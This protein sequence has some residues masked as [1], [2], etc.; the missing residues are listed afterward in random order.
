MIIIYTLALFCIIYYIERKYFNFRIINNIKNFNIKSLI[1]YVFVSI[2]FIFLIRLILNEIGFLNIGNGNF[3]IGNILSILFSIFISPFVEEYIF[4][5]IPFNKSKSILT[6]IIVSLIFTFL[7]STGIF[8]SIFI[9]FLS[10]L[11]SY[12]YIKK[13]S[14]IY[15]YS[16]HSTYN[17]ISSI[18]YYT[19][20][21]YKILII[22]ASILSIIL[23]SVKNVRKKYK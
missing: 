10:I 21:S 14:I 3:N 20:K 17:L 11:F 15:T 23:V 13:K 16:I 5:Y 1:Y 4:R 22:I 12:I 9:F 18:I 8:E 7:H 19:G 2:S 6:I